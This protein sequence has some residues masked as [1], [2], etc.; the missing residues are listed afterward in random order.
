MQRL[1]RSPEALRRSRRISFVL[2]FATLSAC[3]GGG[4]GGGGVVNPPTPKLGSITVSP[5]TMN[6]NAGSTATI[7]VTAL[8]ESGASMG[9]TS[10][11]SYQTST[12]AVAVVSSS[13][14]VLGLST[15]ASTITV[16]LTISGITKTA[17]V[18]V[19]VAG[20]LP[21]SNNVAASSAGTDFQPALVAISVGG[22]VNFSFGQLTHNVTFDVSGA[23]ANI[24]NSSQTTASRTFTTAGDFAYHCSIH[25]SAMSGVVYVR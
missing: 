13:G 10:G 2:L 19:T 17:T 3:G 18:N 22:S 12:T 6:L 8:D 21:G 14:T 4:D 1:I 7:A 15:G 23:P 9:V 25:G 5:G 11:F 20:T 16:S 24:G